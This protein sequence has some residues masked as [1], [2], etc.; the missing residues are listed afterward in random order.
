MRFSLLTLIGLSALARPAHAVPLNAC[1][2]ADVTAQD[3]QCPSGTGPCTISKDFAI[4]NGCTLDFGTRAVTLKGGATLVILSRTVTINAGSFTVA[5]G[6]EVNARGDQAAPNDRGGFVTIQTTGNVTLQK[7]SQLGRIDVSGTVGTGTVRIIAGGTVTIAGKLIGNNIG[8]TAG[9]GTIIIKAGGDI[10]TQPGSILQAIGSSGGG[11]SGSIDLTAAGRIDLGAIVDLSG[12]DG[13]TLNLGAWGDVVVRGLQGDATGDTG[14]GGELDI[15]AGTSIQVLSSNVNLRGQTSTDGMSGGCGGIADIESLYGD[16]TVSTSI[17][18]DGSS[19]DGSG[20]TVTLTSAGSLFVNAPSSVTARGGGALSCGGEIDLTAS[21]NIT[22]AATV[23]ASAGAGGGS[24][25][26]VAAGDVSITGPMLASAPNTDAFGGDITVDAGEQGIGSLTVNSTMDSSGGNCDTFNICGAGGTI[27]LFACNVTLN[28]AASLLVRGGSGGAAFLT[29]RE[30]LTVN[31][32]VNATRVPGAGIDGQNQVGHPSRKPPVIGAGLVTPAPVIT[33]RTTCIAFDTPTGCLPPCPTCG[34]GLVEYPETCDTPGTPVSCDGCSFYC[35]IENC[36]DANPCTTDSCTPNLGCR[37]IGVANGTSCSDG[38]VCNGVE[39][40]QNALCTAVPL[41]CND[42]NTCTIDTC[43][44]PTGCQHVNA[45]P[46][47]NCTDGNACTA[48]DT[49]DA[50][51][52]CVPGAPLVCN[53]N[54]ECTT[55]TC[56]PAT[57]CVFANRTGSCTDDANPCTADVCSAGNCTHPALTNGTAC[58]DGAFCTVSDNC[59]NG[60]CLGG[61]ARDCSDTNPCTI[62]SCDETND[63]CVHAPAGVGS[64]CSDGNACTVGDVCDASS[65]CQPGPAANCDDGNECTTDSCNPVTGCVHTNRGGTC[66]DDGNACTSDVCNAGACTHPNRTNGTSCE[67]GAF[68]TVGDSCLNGVCQPGSPQ[69]CNDSNPCTTDTCN[70][71]TD[72]CDHVNLPGGT[73]CSDGDACTVGDACD[74]G[75][76]C[77]PGPPANCDDGSECTDDSCNSATGCVHANRTG[78]C[79]DDGNVCTTDVCGGGVCT[80]PA[81]PNGTV[82]DDGAFCTAGDSCQGGICTPGPA[83][84]C[85]DTSPCTADSCNEITDTCDH[86]PLPVGAPCT[87]NNACTV[88]DACDAGGACQ[89]GGA[90]NCDDG[91]ECTNDSCNP[92]TG[93]VHANRTGPCTDDGNTCTTDVCNAGACTHPS[94]PNGTACDDGAFCTVGDACQGG[95]CVPGPAR[96]CNDNNACTSDSCDEAHDTCVQTP[97]VPCCGNGATEAPEQCDDGNTV[98]T[99]ACRNNCQLAVCGDGVVRT[100]VEQCDL[101]ANNSNA[102]DAACRTDCRLRRCGDGIVDPGAGEQCDDGNTI[103]GDGCSPTCTSELSPTAQ[104]IPG[105]PTSTT[106]CIVEWAAEH[107]VLDKNGIPTL[108]QTCKDGDPSCDYGN[109]SGECVFHV[110]LCA[111]NHDVRLPSCTPG[112]GGAGTAASIDVTKPSAKGVVAHPEDGPLRNAVVQ[113]AAAA[114]QGGTFDHCGPRLDVRV[115]FKAPGVKGTRALSIKATSTGSLVDV[116]SLKLLCTP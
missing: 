5:P 48:V 67:D 105:K 35:Q 61:G 103:D 82:C 76:S 51:G 39:A 78:P 86:V 30:Q 72:Q 20:G 56:N 14:A 102:P 31:G 69:S 106:E 111:N 16:L 60:T 4:G 64:S 6:G 37:H 104:R 116:D 71:A 88:G 70:E 89:P 38:L 17:L 23:D 24:V 15:I 33:P 74:A 12:A 95:S 59:Q 113:A 110:W 94:R 90:A 52:T 83:R 62:D 98:D 107:P 80:H 58:N 18:T 73:A 34:N 29:A 36:N 1:T 100:G 46:G 77:Q 22:S 68:C 43:V 9:G 32:P 49:C 55:D 85:S 84:D 21:R 115:P 19:P 44:E 47:A 109:V 50:T 57:G 63:Q 91:N 26:V 66:T 2:A 40:C 7:A 25:A 42:G 92:A 8:P 54:R 27:D 96:S 11:V 65:V 114:R 53:D 87:D 101:G 97:I 28:A 10:I 93:C 79:T 45:P 108:K 112:P 99:D 41:N 81:Q 75:G 3:S 13:G